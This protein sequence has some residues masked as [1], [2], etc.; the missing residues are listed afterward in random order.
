[1]TTNLSHR[2]PYRF[3]F[4]TNEFFWCEKCFAEYFPDNVVAKMKSTTF[5][6]EDIENGKNREGKRIEIPAECMRHPRSPI[7]YMPLAPDIPIVVAARLSLSFPGLISAVPLQT[8][9]W[10]RVSEKRKIVTVWFSD[11][12]ICSNFPMRFFDAVWPTRPTFGINLSPEDPDRPAMMVW[13]ASPKTSGPMPRYIPIKSLGGFVKS[14]LDTMQN[15]NDTT[16]ITMPGFRDRIVVVRQKA[17]EG[18]MN[19]KMSPDVIDELAKRGAEAG[20]NIVYGDSKAKLPPFDFDLHRWIRYR[21]SM[22]GFDEQLS[23]MYDTWVN[24][25]SAFITESSHKPIEYEDGECVFVAGAEDLVATTSLMN[26]AEELPSLKNPA[27]Q[28]S[29]P[30]PRPEVRLV[31][32]L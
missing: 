19:L 24:G 9:D 20:H 10:T 14:V 16:Q 23:G 15:W 17:G 29:V 2:R 11:G 7:Y 5:R 6:V 31:P 1:M 12:G 26:F 25:M 4:D 13:R 18:G 27:T 8:V 22:A 32:P 3:P 30:H 21:V 28:G